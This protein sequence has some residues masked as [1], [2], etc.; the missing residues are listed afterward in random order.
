MKLPVVPMLI[1]GALFAGCDPTGG[2]GGGGGLNNGDGTTGGLPGSETTSS[3]SLTLSGHVTYDYVPSV[4][5]NDGATLDF[6]NAEERPVRN[7]VVRVLQD[8]KTVL[9]TTTTDDNGAYSVTVQ[10]SGGVL[11]VQALARTTTPPI[12]VEDNTDGD[13]TWGAAANVGSATTVDVHATHGW[14]GSA[15]SASKRLAAAFAILDSMYTASQ[16]FL[17]ERNVNF[18]QLH[19]N[20][21]PENSPEQG[22]KTKGQIS[23]SHFAP[24]DGQIYVLGLEGA[25]TDEFDSNV[26]VHEWGHYFEFNLSR[27]DSPGGPHGGGNNVLDPR[28]AFGEGWGTSLA[29][30]ALN[31]TDYVDTS[32][33]NGVLTGWSS[34]AENVNN[35]DA[36]PSAFSENTIIRLLWDLHDTG[37]NESFDTTSFSMGQIYDVMVNHEKNTRAVTT[38]GSFITGMKGLPGANLTAIDTLLAAYN[39]GPISDDFGQGDPALYDMY[40]FAT[41]LP[42]SHTVQLGGGNPY[43]SWQ[44]NEY[45]VFT[46][47]GGTMRLN[48]TSSYPF[49]I[50]LYA[51]GSKLGEIDGSSGTVDYADTTVS[52]TTYVAVV[53]GL[54]DQ[55]GDYPVTINI[56]GQ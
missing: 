45:Y 9:A 54:Y 41:A 16:S 32:W 50:S 13:P 2:G 46:G 27:S 8:K 30:M 20:W 47:T 56:S 38:L 19:V 48:V 21:S 4:A 31:K 29:A 42:F 51:N 34:D 52:G 55:Q 18:P 33:S 39:I 24:D 14:T 25:D 7:A 49:Y 36:Q 10:A 17:A 5:T 35:D 40:V 11:H 1:A 28:I 23:T 53:T 15:Y 43:N 22:D 26:I 37:T 6:A 3:G 12:Q 44:Q